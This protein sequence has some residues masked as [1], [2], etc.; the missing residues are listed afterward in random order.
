MPQGILFR[1]VF[2]QQKPGAPGALWLILS[3]SCYPEFAI[4]RLR[5]KIE[6]VV[7]V[8]IDNVCNLM[9]RLTSTQYYMLTATSPATIR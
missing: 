6:V 1:A 3:G 4:S 8:S 7:V 9:L 2:P 5:C